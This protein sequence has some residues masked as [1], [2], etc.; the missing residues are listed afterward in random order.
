MKRIALHVCVITLILGCSD[1]VDRSTPLFTSVIGNYTEAQLNEDIR[2]REFLTRETILSKH[3]DLSRFE[4][5]LPKLRGFWH[6]GIIAEQVLF[7]A[8]ESQVGRDALVATEAQKC[9]EQSVY[10]GS[11]ATG[12]MGF[13]ALRGKAAEVGLEKAF[14][15]HY[16]Q[17]L[18]LRILRDAIAKEDTGFRET[19]VWIFLTNATNAALR[20]EAKNVEIYQMASNVVTRLRK[21]EDFNQVYNEC[22]NL[23]P[24]EKA[25]TRKPVDYDEVDFPGEEG[26]AIWNAVKSLPDGG[27]S[28]VYETD[29]GLVIY[30]VLKHIN[31]SEQTGQF[32]LKMGKIVVR[33]VIVQRI[34]SVNEARKMVRECFANDALEQRLR[35]AIASAEIDFGSSVT[36]LSP[37]LRHQLEK[38]GALKKKETQHEELR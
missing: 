17:S 32:A 15:R 20:A 28:E 22:C 9:S 25:E 24:E 27:V 3:G 2:L 14:D 13:D 4:K 35:A 19:N 23:E 31:K 37:Q 29:E 1:H 21:G 6:D 5:D 11:V 16:S 10:V 38:I 33:R 34:P 8:A 36:N 18:N 12:A 26:K 30:K 7:F